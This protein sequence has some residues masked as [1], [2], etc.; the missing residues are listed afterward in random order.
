MTARLSRPVTASW[1]SLEPG[2]TSIL[3]SIAL[4]DKREPE[5]KEEV[6]D[7][8]EDTDEEQDEIGGEARSAALTGELIIK[9]G[10]LCLFFSF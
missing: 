1:E 2:A 3:S 8:D 10:V 4:P 5:D 9:E 7:N 6:E